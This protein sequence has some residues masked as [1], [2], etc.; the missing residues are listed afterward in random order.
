MSA[1]PRVVVVGS[2]AAG[3]AAASAAASA[4]AQ[5]TVLE[6]AALVGGTTCL[7][8]GVAWIPGNPDDPGRPSTRCATSQS[9]GLGD[10]DR[11]AAAVFVREAAG[12]AAALRSAAPALA[13]PA[14]SRLS[15][16]VPGRRGAGGRSI[17]PDPMHV[18]AGARRA[19]A[20][21]PNVSAPITYRELA[22]GEWDR[23]AIAAARREGVLTLGPR[24]DRRAA[25][26]RARAPGSTCAR[27]SAARRCCARTTARRRRRTPTASEHRGRVVLASGG[28][29]RDPALVRSLLRGPMVAPAGVP[30]N[31]G[32]G[33]RMAM[34]AGCELGNL[35]EAWWSPALHVPG[36]EID[37]SRSSGSCSPSVHGPAASSS[38]AAGGGSPTR[39]RTTT[40]WAARC[41]T[42]DPTAFAFPRVPA[43]MVFDGAYRGRYS[44]GPLR[45][46]AP[47]PPWLRRGDDLAALAGGDRRA[48]RRARG[49]RRALQRLVAGR[50]RRRLRPRRPRV[51]PL[52]GRSP[53]ARTRS[54]AT[55]REPPFY[56]I[57]IL[58]GCLGTKG[59]PRT[60]DRGRALLV[61]TG[62][63]LP[64][65]YAAGNASRQPVRLCLPRRGWDDRPR[66]GVRTP[67][68]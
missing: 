55:L 63:P 54:S 30:T 58:P 62:A 53:R 2:G 6:A 39:R 36:E 37:G 44:L 35:S 68:R 25:G 66:A 38:T 31:V 49:D 42:F 48:G 1:S 10:H 29:E 19:R 50:P 28:F 41:T 20:L 57:E 51:R 27:A 14:V 22:A 43:W 9:L 24:A 33:L 59:G 26:G 46:G 16:R 60:D 4:G 56:A 64:G 8:G 67:R 47:D 7:S 3:M 21:A 40:T 65:L 32:D 13:R 61:Q 15:R 18:D 34:A 52:H 11:A 5:V 23:E 45:R 12:V 17:E